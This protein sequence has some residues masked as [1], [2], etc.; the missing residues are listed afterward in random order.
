MYG[1]NSGSKEKN[2]ERNGREMEIKIFVNE[3]LIIPQ[4]SEFGR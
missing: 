1:R 3:T 4:L 2:G